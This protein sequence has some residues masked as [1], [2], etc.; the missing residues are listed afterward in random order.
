MRRPSVSDTSPPRSHT[1]SV[2]GSKLPLKRDSM[3]LNDSACRNKT[4]E[5]GREVSFTTVFIECS[6]LLT[7]DNSPVF[8][9]P[10]AKELAASDAVPLSVSHALHLSCR[11]NLSS[12]LQVQVGAKM[13]THSLLRQSIC[14]S[15][16]HGVSTRSSC[17]HRILAVGF[18]G[19]FAERIAMSETILISHPFVSETETGSVLW[20]A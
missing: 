17:Q 19:V 18:L 11:R 2:F 1:E 14:Q 8:C 10:W 15:V 7:C 13:M 4:I 20:K 3:R 9:S 6:M 16:K 5:L 12:I